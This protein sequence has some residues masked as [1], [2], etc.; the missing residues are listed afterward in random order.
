MRVPAYLSRYYTSGEE[1][2]V[3]LSMLGLNLAQKVKEKHCKRNGIGGFYAEDAYLPNRL[4]IEKWIRSELIKKGGLPKTN[5]PVYM[6]LGDSPKGEYDIRLDIQKNA[7]LITIDI[8]KIDLS[9][10]TFT[11][12]DSMY[13]F[14]YDENNI[15]IGDKRTNTPKVYLYHEL[16]HVIDKF[17]VY[18]AP[19]EHYI[20]AQVWD[21]E[22]LN[23]LM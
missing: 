12:P 18:N 6:T 14:L 23:K 3:S 5:S 2:F 17:S 10:V 1:P 8:D 20:E 16:Q 9:V 22:M 4:E 11:Y 19:Y 15:K 7:Q 21:I 13:E